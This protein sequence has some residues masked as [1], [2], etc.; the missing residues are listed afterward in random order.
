MN[1]VA[2]IGFATQIN[3]KNNRNN[4]NNTKRKVT[5][6]AGWPQQLAYAN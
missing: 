5:N 3:Y 2:L 4:N 6:V 1:N